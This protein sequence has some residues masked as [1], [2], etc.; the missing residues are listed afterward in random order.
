MKPI[1]LCPICGGEVRQETVTKI[2]QGGGDTA[3]LT[4]EALVCQLCGE[5]YYSLD[6]A[7]K[8]EDLRAKLK[9]RETEGLQETGKSF[10]VV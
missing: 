8:I 2:V 5:H 10:T 7:L 1:D 9:R 3:S 4:L 6:N